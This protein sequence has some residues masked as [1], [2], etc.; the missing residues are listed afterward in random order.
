[1]RSW[2]VSVTLV[3]AR[4][5]LGISAAGSHGVVLSCAT[6]QHKDK[7]PGQGN[8][9][10]RQAGQSC[11]VSLPNH[12]PPAA[13]GWRNFRMDASDGPIF[14]LRKRF[15]S[16]LPGL[17]QGRAHHRP[18]A[19]HGLSAR[20]PH[21]PHRRRET[22]RDSLVVSI[23]VNPTQFGPNEDLDRYPRDL[24]ATSHWP[25]HMA[26]TWCSRPSP[27]P[28]TPRTTH[29]GGRFRACARTLRGLAAIHFAGLCTVVLKLLNL[30]RP[31]WAVVPAR[32]LAAAGHFAAHGA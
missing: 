18:C 19:H 22:P 30:V 32:G 31:M 7:R 26:R 20:R 24:P 6:F 14:P 4:M 25:R 5:S 29:L 2:R 27:A 23:F 21:E 3:S 9:S 15:A 28:C 17:E 11:H 10:G 8:I 12:A 16:D 1:M 13:A